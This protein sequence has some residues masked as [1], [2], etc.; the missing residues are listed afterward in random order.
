[1]YCIAAAVNNISGLVFRDFRSQHAGIALNH[2]DAVLDAVLQGLELCGRIATW[3]AMVPRLTK[4]AVRL[5]ICNSKAISPG[6]ISSSNLQ[7][8]AIFSSVIELAHIAGLRT[9]AQAS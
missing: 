6:C 9:V 1:M 7:L 5:L 4:N 8:G 2:L 3:L